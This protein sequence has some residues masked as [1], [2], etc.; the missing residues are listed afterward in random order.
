MAIRIAINGF[1]RIGRNVFR[2]MHARG[3]AFEVVALNGLCSPEDMAQQ[4][5]YDT[6]CGPF[7]GTVVPG[8]NCVNVDGRDILVLS[9]RD[10]SKL[11]WAELDVDFVVEATGAFRTRAENQMHINSGAKKVMLTVPPKD[12]IDNM[13]VLG[14]N[15]HTLRPDQKLLSIASCTT[16]C[17]APLAKVLHE[18]FGIKGGVISTVHAYT[19]DQRLLD[20][21]HKDTRRGRA[22]AV[23]IIPT[24]TGAARAVGQVMPELKG[25]LDGI[26]IRVPVPVGSAIDLVFEVE[27][28][29][30]TVEEVNAAV[31]A[32]AEGSMK[33][34]IQYIND[35]IVSSDVRHNPY[36]TVFDSL[37]TMVMNGN[38]VKI[39][40]WYDNEWGYSNRVCDL[41][42]QA[43]H[44]K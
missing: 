1:G 21:R 22:A 24:S 31:K 20:V 6:I 30:V 36:S 40:A 33:G 13:V 25:K 26:A 17:L 2:I 44:L 5:K 28:G 7:S 41:I 34:I 8:D 38:L 9:E 27:R 18:A 43:H 35:P 11:P 42:H 37:L 10:T 16:T 32:S 15:D 39:I 4:I 3:D 29:P 23:N 14:V 12:R 19:N